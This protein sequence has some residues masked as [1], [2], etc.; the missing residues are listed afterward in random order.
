MVRL[1]INW[2][3]IVLILF[4]AT[5]IWQ[6]IKHGFVTQ[7]LVITFF[8][9][10]LFLG[11]WLFPHVL[12]IHD[13]TLLTIVNGNLV[14]IFAAIMAIIGF[15]LG[16]NFHISFGK[17]RWHQLENGLSVIMSL[18][19]GLIAVWLVAAMIGRLP[20]AG[21][22]NSANDSLIAQVLDQHLPPIPAVFAEFSRQLNPKSIPEIFIHTPLQTEQYVP[23][24]SPIAARIASIDEYSV[25]RITS[26][27]CG[28][29]V[30]GS[31]IVVAPNLVLTNAH[32]IAGVHRP[33]VKYGT[34]SYVGTPVLFDYNLDVAILRLSN[35]PATPL[36]IFNGTVA[37]GTG[38]VVLG[39]PGGNFTILPAVVSEQTQLVTDNLYNVGTV[40]R[41]VYEVQAPVGPGSSGGP[42][43]LQN[44]QVA[45]VIFARNG[46]LNSYAYALTST[47]VLSKVHQAERATRRISTGV[48]LSD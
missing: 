10:G 25:V 17:N 41:Q 30:T 11:G 15:H 2:F 5:L 28:G 9:G 36:T 40:D 13:Q 35:L 34:Q 33:I 45:G 31:G 48:C 8:F 42:M 12:P 1:Y 4:L 37:P 16:H 39:Y 46:A 6:G 43:I 7:F 3:D 26:F 22:S 19:F 18:S 32:V 47:S 27:G 38:V 23:I 14:L 20:F 24:A 29:I 21:L 44:G